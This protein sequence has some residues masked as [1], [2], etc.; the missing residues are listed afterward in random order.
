MPLLYVLYSDQ[1]G[2]WFGCTVAWLFQLSVLEQ[3]Y[4]GGLDGEPIRV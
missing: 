4:S 2:K 1:S 3:A